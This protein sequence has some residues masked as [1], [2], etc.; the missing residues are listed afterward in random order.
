MITVPYGI[1]INNDNL[2]LLYI[3]RKVDVDYQQHFNSGSKGLIN[4]IETM[5]RILNLISCI[6]LVYWFSVHLL[7]ITREIDHNY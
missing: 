7:L 6:I 2:I 5:Y 3:A 1:I 4:K